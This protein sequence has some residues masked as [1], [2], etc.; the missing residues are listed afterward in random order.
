MQKKKLHT[1]AKETVQYRKVGSIEH[2]SV[3]W[4]L[5]FGLVE[6]KNYKLRIYHKFLT[7][8]QN[9]VIERFDRNPNLLNL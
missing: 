7:Y 9:Q 3:Q 1:L 2:C 4:Y 6:L 8:F 5:P